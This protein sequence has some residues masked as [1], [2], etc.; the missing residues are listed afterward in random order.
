[1]KGYVGGACSERGNRTVVRNCTCLKCDS[2]GGTTGC[3]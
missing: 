3:S 1:M 2:C